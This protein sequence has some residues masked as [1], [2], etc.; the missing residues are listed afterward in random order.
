M[1]KRSINL[2]ILGIITFLGLL[3]TDVAFGSATSSAVGTT[4][5]WIMLL[6]KLGWIL[7]SAVG[8][9]IGLGIAILIFDL[10]STKIEEWEEIKKGNIG[11]AI[12][13][14][15]LVVMSAVILFVVYK[16]Y[17]DEAIIKQ[18]PIFTQYL[19]AFIWGISSSIGFAISVGISIWV[20]DLLSTQI[21][22]WDEIKKGNVGVALIFTSLIVMSG[23]LLAKNFGSIAIKTAKLQHLEP[24]FGVTLSTMLEGLGYGLVATIGFVFSIGLAIKVFDLISTQIE[25]WEEIKK[26]NMGVALIFISLIVMAGLILF[27][28]ASL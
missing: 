28:K 2:S 14:T 10:I 16:S 3:L 13:F 24:S 27:F 23:L 8:Y 5:T 19:T 21:E 18:I 9:T 4:S 1:K 17:H 22:E 20:F 6:H 12:I 25:E 7:I 11:V 15:S 26:N